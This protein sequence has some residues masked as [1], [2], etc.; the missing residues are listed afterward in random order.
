MFK[1]KMELT[2]DPKEAKQ[3]HREKLANLVDKYMDDVANGKAEGIRN[4]KE[5][6]EVIKMD[7]LMLGEA[8]DRTDNTFD[9]KRMALVSQVI[10]PSDPSVQAL[11]SNM[12]KTLNSANDSEDAQ[13][14]INV[15]PIKNSEASDAEE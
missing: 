2:S 7:L 3:E 6:V 15:T 5:L 14:D 9:D 8:T 10:D 1:K 4:A 12:M 11:I 13:P